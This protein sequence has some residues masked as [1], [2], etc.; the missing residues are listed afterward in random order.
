MR[1]NV[2]GFLP[3]NR[4]FVRVFGVFGSLLLAMTALYGF[5]IIPLQQ[6]SLLKVM[7]SQAATVSKSIIQACSDAMLT[8]DFGFIV[9]HNL[10]VLQ[11]N[12][13]MQSVTLF[14]KRGAVMRIEP[15]G[16]DMLDKTGEGLPASAMENESFG[17]I[18]GADGQSFYRY[19][20]PIRFSGVSWGVVQMDFSTAEYNANISEMYRQLALISLLV[21]VVILPVGYIFAR[22]LTRPI[23]SISEAASRVAHGDLSARVNIVRND[24]IGQLSHSFNIMVDALQRSRDQ[25]QDSNQELERKVSARTHE[26]D[27]LNRTLDQRVRDEIGK[28]KAQENLLIHQS[29]LAAMGEMI[30]AIAH[31]WRQ[32]LNALSLVMQNIR[33]QHAMGTLT[34]AS[35]ARMQEKSGQLVQRMSSTIDEFRNFFKPGKHAQSFLLAQAVR[36]SVDIMEGV[37]KNHSINWVLECDETLEL[38]GVQGEFSQVILNLLSNAKD[39]LLASKQP[40]PNIILRA[41]LRGQHV[42]ISISDN[43]G[44]ISPGILDKI[45]EP[46]FTT[47]DEGQGT[48]IGLYMSKMIVE[49]NMNGRLRAE[50][51]DLGA[52]FTLEIP[53]PPPVDSGFGSGR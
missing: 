36:S 50:N 43:G 27:E 6:D 21:V 24:E 18:D 7:Y 30:G 34:E 1:R 26:L 22:W 23:V 49:N 40:S 4:M 16:W 39:A 47:K 25:L 5:L 11:N 14:P 13:S 41:R 33:M 45:F 20:A 37:F 35:M 2:L 32:P 46:Y 29:R 53:L 8:D 52:T 51:T 48:G 12:K 31:Q 42:E 28:R 38:F 10:Q 3:A 44:G 17:L 15:K 19:S 9:E